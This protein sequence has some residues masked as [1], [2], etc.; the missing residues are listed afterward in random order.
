[1]EVTRDEEASGPAAEGWHLAGEVCRAESRVPEYRR[2]V[3][4]PGALRRLRIIE[5]CAEAVAVP[6]VARA[7]IRCATEGTCYEHIRPPIGRN[8]FYALVLRFY[9]ELDRVLWEEK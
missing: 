3:R 1:M 2:R 4:S 6:A 9:I 7:I 8:Q 5:A